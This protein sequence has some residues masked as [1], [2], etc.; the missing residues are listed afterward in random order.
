M[1]AAPPV[2]TITMLSSRRAKNDSYHSARRS[3]PGRESGQTVFG[4]STFD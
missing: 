2:T 4:V 1:R 3:P